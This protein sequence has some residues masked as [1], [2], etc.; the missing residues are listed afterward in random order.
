[1]QLMRIIGVSIKKPLDKASRKDI[2]RF[3]A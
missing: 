3:L 2:Q 1:M